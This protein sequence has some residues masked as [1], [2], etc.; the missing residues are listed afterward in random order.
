MCEYQLAPGETIVAAST[1]YAVRRFRRA[2]GR[3]RLLRLIPDKPTLVFYFIVEQSAYRSIP[4]L[5]NV[6]AR[7]NMSPADFDRV[8]DE[9]RYTKRQLEQKQKETNQ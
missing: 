9:T 4:E 6:S 7:P 2:I 3:R 5:N 8:E 1:D